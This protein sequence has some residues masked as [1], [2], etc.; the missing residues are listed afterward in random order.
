MDWI[1]DGR[2][3]RQ[4][5]TFVAAATEGL[6]RTAYLMTGEAAD[7]EDLVQD[8]L[9]RV[10]RHWHRVR[11]MEHPAA[12]ARRVLVNLALDGAKRRSR[13]RAELKAP[14]G[15]QEHSDE[16]A[17]HALRQVDDLA[18]FRWALAQ[19]PAGQRAVLVLRYWEDLAVAEVAEILGCSTG[20]VKSAAS[21]GAARL[22]VALANG[23][24][25]DESVAS[26]IRKGATR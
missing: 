14:E 3:K 17:A 6:F 16:S 26:T 21:R 4:F 18:E 10:A 7:A 11:S 23:Q 19:V 8:A 24:P 1:G 22:A 15:G 2:A 5:E 20:T 13:E 9:I 25:A 12:Y